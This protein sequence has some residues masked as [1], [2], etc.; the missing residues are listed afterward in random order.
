VSGQQ[1]LNTIQE[2]ARGQNPESEDVRVVYGVV[3]SLTPPAV[4]IDDRLTIPADLIIITPFITSVV[5][6]MITGPVSS[7]EIWRDIKIGDNLA[8]L[9]LAKGQQYLALYRV[10]M[11]SE[12]T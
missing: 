5:V 11:A 2:L 3:S 10:N 6:P 1:I 12:P 4:K 8:M 9:R 7:I